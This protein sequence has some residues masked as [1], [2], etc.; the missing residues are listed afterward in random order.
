MNNFDEFLKEKAARSQREVPSSVKERVRSTLSKLP[1]TQ[2]S[3]RKLRIFP[4]IAA[5]AAAF[6]F[7][8][9]VLLP[10]ISS[11]Y[12]GALGKIPVIGG[13]VDVVT[14]RNYAYSDDNHEMNI[15]VPKIQG[16]A[17]PATYYINK[18]VDELTEILY[19]RFNEELKEIGDEGHS[20]V[21]VDYAVVTNTDKWF[22]LKIEVFE[23]A[24]SS[25]TY[26]E[27][28]HIDK[29]NGKIVCLGDIAKS[30]KLYSALE[31]EIRTQ[32]RREMQNDENLIYWVEDS[33]FGE[34]IIKLSSAHNFYWS[35]DGDIV[36]PFD[37]YEVAP[38]YMG[39]PEFTVSRELILE[40]LKEEYK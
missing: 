27:Y 10:N 14:I 21:Y 8:T 1:D 36:I 40:Y 22:T 18:S 15:N 12:A 28:Y 23:A 31:N 6:V 16:E 19:D 20:S 2:Y 11:V 25:N 26:Y 38:G 13:I 7:V 5:T 37:K 24:G 34:D 32:M 39:T 3:V 17:D 29:L 30:D 4:K 33:P 35:I 9:L